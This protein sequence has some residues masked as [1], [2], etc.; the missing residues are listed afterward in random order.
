[1]IQEIN[2]CVSMVKTKKIKMKKR[3]IF[4]LLAGLF[5]TTAKVHA[6]HLTDRVNLTAVL[7]GDQQ[8]PAV[9]TNA[10]GTAVFTLNANMDT[11]SFLI[12]T[13]GLS[14]EIAAAHIHEGKRGTSGGVVLDLDNFRKF[15]QFSGIITGTALNK[16]FLNKLLMG[17]LYVNIHTAS[18]PNGEIRGQIEIESDW[19]FFGMADGDQQVPSVTTPA[20]GLVTAR[21]SKDMKWLEIR[22]LSTGLSGGIAAAHFHTGA[23]GSNGGVVLDLSDSVMGNAIMARV[24]PMAFLS[25]LLAGRIY[26]NI[27]T[28]ANP[29]GEIRAQLMLWDGF[30]FDGWLNGA[31]QVP[32]N[33]SMGMGLGAF[34]YNASLDSLWSYVITD[35]LSDT[36][37]GA[38][39]H[40]GAAGVNGGVAVDLTDFIMGDK[41]QMI[42][43]ITTGASLTTSFWKNLLKGEIYINLHNDLNAN[44]EIRSQLNR[45]MRETY[46]IY[47]NGAQQSPMVMTD[48]YGGGFASIDRDQ[49]NVYFAVSAGKLSGPIAA[50]HFHKALKGQNGGVLW[51]VTGAFMKNASEDFGWASWS[52]WDATPFNAAAAR[53]FRT[54]SVYL[55][56][57]TNANQNGE[58]RGQ[59]WRGFMTYSLPNTLSQRTWDANAISVYPNPVRLGGKLIIEG[60]TSAEKVM[61]LDLSGR[62]VLQG[63]AGELFIQANA[64]K[65]GMYLLKAENIG[66]ARTIQ[67]MP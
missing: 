25:D 65:P 56:I 43:G 30:V 20:K 61:I 17:Q 49:S 45:Y 36:T 7:T 16:T 21:L 37:T 41:G 60:L 38:H 6:A 50:A 24:N 47:L 31:Q 32:A 59:A 40:I 19:S 14:G 53:A 63:N 64:F 22:A 52:K 62:T 29:N 55:N 48:G 66:G 44:G 8:T 67:I 35:G 34:R 2:G 33:A 10:K 26:L 11:V 15:N 5:F 12:T 42:W 1:M 4:T 28:A 58:I 18:N 13:S 51:D 54:D 27:H 9:T 39:L 3:T 23:K 57:H 46:T